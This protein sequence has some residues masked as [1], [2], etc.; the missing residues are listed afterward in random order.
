MCVGAALGMTTPAPWEGWDAAPHLSQPRLLPRA[1][2]PRTCRSPSSFSV[3]SVLICDTKLNIRAA[4]QAEG[5][6]AGAGVSRAVQPQ[7]SAAGS[8]QHGGARMAGN[9]WDSMAPTH[10]MKGPSTADSRDCVSKAG[11]GKTASW[12]AQVMAAGA[13]EGEGGGGGGG[14]YG[15]GKTGSQGGKATSQ[16]KGFQPVL[17]LNPRA[18]CPAAAAAAAA[19]TSAAAAASAPVPF[20]YSLLISR[21]A[22]F[23]IW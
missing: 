10:K 22:A 9:Q 21:A 18:C 6:I 11:W 3:T 20:M 19:A 1:C 7:G 15:R 8:R 13:V 23:I 14:C 16:R 12:G 5:G 17:P 2:W 4:L